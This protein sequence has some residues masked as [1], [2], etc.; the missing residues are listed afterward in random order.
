MSKNR[1]HSRRI[2]SNER[3]AAVRR[4]GGRGDQNSSTQLDIYE[5][6]TARIIVNRKTTKW[7]YFFNSPANFANMNRGGNNEGSAATAATRLEY[8]PAAW[9]RLIHTWLCTYL[10][11]ADRPRS[12]SV[13]RRTATGAYILQY[14]CRWILKASSLPAEHVDFAALSEDVGAEFGELVKVVETSVQDSPHFVLGILPLPEK[15][16]APLSKA[17]ERN[18][19]VI[20]GSG[21][22]GSKRGGDGGLCS[23]T[24]ACVSMLFFAANLGVSLWILQSYMCLY[25][26]P[27]H[28]V[29]HVFRHHVSESL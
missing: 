8:D 3:P 2:R 18:M 24:T 12:V 29:M 28:G 17:I 22:G 19:K 16:H 27:W 20:E 4:P 5:S 25:D 14:D 6:H 9:Q 15:A 11:A 21:G 26:N 23:R 10:G 1:I 13:E 7:F